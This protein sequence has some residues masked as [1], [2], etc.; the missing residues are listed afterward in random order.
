MDLLTI[1]PIQSCN[2]SCKECPMK[3]WTYPTDSELNKLKNSV[4]LPYIRKNTSPN[5]H[6][7]HLSGGE[8]GL[9]PEIHN[10]VSLLSMDGYRG[11]INTN[12]TLPIPNT[13]NFKRIAAWHL[14]YFHPP[15]YYDVVLILRNSNDAWQRKVGY[16]EKNRIPYKTLTYREYSIPLSKRKKDPL[17]EPIEVIRS[18][19]NWSIIYSS[20][21]IAACCSQTTDSECTIF[22]DSPL[23]STPIKKGCSR[24]V[25]VAGIE[26]FL[27]FAS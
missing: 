1:Y 14:D 26:M 10:L 8:P 12:G 22:N 13:K 6:V 5:T 20:G 11:I 7:I 16:C 27:D 15:K 24:C 25:N 17:E 23:L 3:K 4:L 9:Y 21:Q 2:L 19:D 18:I